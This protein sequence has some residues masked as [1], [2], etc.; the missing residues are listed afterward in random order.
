MNCD[1]TESH[2]NNR[3]DI[4][5]EPLPILQEKSKRRKP[6]KHDRR[7][8]WYNL[9]HQYQTAEIFMDIFFVNK[10]LFFHAKTEHI[11]FRSIESLPSQKKKYQWN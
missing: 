10:L 11:G 5:G 3:N 6:T 4:Y 8:L 7:E 2:I 9:P 1:T